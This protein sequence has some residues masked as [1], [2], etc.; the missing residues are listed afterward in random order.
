[1]IENLELATLQEIWWILIATLGAVFLF[2]NF[3]QGGQTLLFDVA[4]TEDEKTLIVNSLGRKWELTFTTLVTFGG[5]IFASFPKLYSTSFGGAY[6]VWTIILFSFIIQAVSYEYRKKPNNFLGQK[7]YE[8]FLLINGVVGVL[9]IGAAVGTFFTGA[10]FKLNE[11]NFVTWTHSLRGL[12]AAFNYFNLSLG[13]FLVFN[14]RVLGAQYLLNNLD[15][16]S[17]PELEDRLRKST[18]MNFLIELVF[19][20][21]VLVSLLVMSGYGVA[22][23]GQIELMSYKFAGNLIANPLNIILLLIGLGLVI[24]SV[25]ITKFKDAN[26]GI[27]FG[28][29]GTVLVGLVVFFLVGFNNS[30]IYPS[31]THPQTSL[32]IYNASSTHYTLT[33]MTYVAF[34]I[35][36]VIAYVAYV[37]RAMDLRKLS[38][39]DLKEKA[40]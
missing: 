26:N 9:L 24:W 25:Y 17:V 18:F 3:V 29:T 11:Y 39:D 16:N 14:A 6:W 35:P 38:L 8:S 21:V 28:G 23:N 15:F 30:C 13:L 27:W 2:L 1:M 31:L 10:N 5:A 20:L 19:L 36:F 32:T 37:W 7:G 22:E 40:Y 34:L 4:K 12:E 33:V